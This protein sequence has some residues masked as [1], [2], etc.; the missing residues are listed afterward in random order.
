MAKLNLDK[1]FKELYLEG[2]IEFEEIDSYVSYWNYSEVTDTLA[3]FLGLNEAEEAV[4]IDD[5][6]EALLDMLDKQKGQEN[7]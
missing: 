3:K 2:Q 7:L 6:D 1:T 5:S 4:W